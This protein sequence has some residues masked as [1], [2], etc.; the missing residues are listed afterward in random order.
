MKK[1][2]NSE[3]SF[4][5]GRIEEINPDL[6]LDFSFGNSKVINSKAF[7]LLCN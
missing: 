2:R 7:K 4:K 5:E 6:D 1:G 3:V